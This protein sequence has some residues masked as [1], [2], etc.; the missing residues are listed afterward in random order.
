MRN[1]GKMNCEKR[2]SE[3]VSERKKLEV[4][5]GSEKCLVGEDRF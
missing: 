2:N 1:C 4:V 5:N 3:K